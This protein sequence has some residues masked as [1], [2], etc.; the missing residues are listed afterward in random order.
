M[1]TRGHTPVYDFCINTLVYINSKQN[2]LLLV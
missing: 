1:P 2:M